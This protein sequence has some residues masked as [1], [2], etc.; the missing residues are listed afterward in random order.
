MSAGNQKG[1]EAIYGWKARIGLLLPSLNTVTEPEFNAMIPEGVSVHTARLLLRLPLSSEGLREMAKD[2]EKAAQTLASAGVKIISFACTSGSLVNG[3]GGDQELIRHIERLTGI[4]AT[5]TSTAVIAAFKKLGVR[6][7]AVGTPYNEE[8]NQAEKSFFEAH[9]IKVVSMKGLDIH[10]A[11]LASTSPEVTYDLACE[12]NTPGAHAV[13]IS[14]MGFKSI[15]VIERL[16]GNL[17][18]YVFSSNTATMWD[19]LK[20]LGIQDQP[21]GYGKLFSTI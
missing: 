6:N 11:E 17:N 4:Q 15:T 3:F 8:V 13:F 12:V 5:T 9:G 21:K 10:G 2:T 1:A 7:V 20:R 14:C 18:K 19:I 16:E